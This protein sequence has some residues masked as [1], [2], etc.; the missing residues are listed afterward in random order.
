MA[1]QNSKRLRQLCK[2]F[3]FIDL[4]LIIFSL[5]E[6]VR[7]VMLH[8]YTLAHW[9][10]LIFYAIFKAVGIEQQQLSYGVFETAAVTLH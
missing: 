6:F 7:Q 3:E 10:C 2:Q 1:Q 8:E 4:M 9:I 5:S